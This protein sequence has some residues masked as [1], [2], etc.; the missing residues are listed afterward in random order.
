MSRNRVSS[1]IDISGPFF[2]YDPK[3]RFRQNI[4]ALA[5]QV[6]DVGAEDVRQ[7]FRAGEP[8]RAL[9]SSGVQPARVSG[10]VVGRTQNWS[11]RRWAVTA[12]ISVTAHGLPA[13][14]AVALMA[15]ASNLE[16]RLHAVRKTAT[17]IRRSK[18]VNTAE[19]LKGIR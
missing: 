19:L 11:G 3:K 6:A 9:V 4:R 18:R 16:G 14:Q 10:H 7:Q 17:R 5:S 13:R 8:G 12:A 2:T 15:A 1:Q